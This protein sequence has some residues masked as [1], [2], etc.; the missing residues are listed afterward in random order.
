MPGQGYDD[1]YDGAEGGA[2]AGLDVPGSVLAAAEAALNRYL[3]LDPEG[4]A[5]FEPLYGR[6][7]VI[8]I[9]GF[10]TR[11]TLIPG[12][13]RLQLFGPYD[14]PA[15]C[16]IR[17]APLSLLRMAV[18][19]RREQEMSSGAIQIEGDTTIAQQLARAMGGLDVDWEEQIAR[20]LGDPIAN[21]LG[22]GL[23]GAREWGRKSGDTLAADIK[24]YLEEEGRLIPSRYELDAFLGEVDVVRDDVER[25]EARLAR[26]RAKLDQPPPEA[27]P[28]KRPAAKKAAARKSGAGATAK[29]GGASE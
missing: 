26:L 15:D 29:K 16:I 21:Q 9:T 2:R 18:S 23:R 3:D 6:I 28:P 17:G 5:G 1:D 8:E 24:E 14:A 4:A 27:T 25:L 11:I 12:P 22:R 19:E 20:I 10:G 13:D 7:I